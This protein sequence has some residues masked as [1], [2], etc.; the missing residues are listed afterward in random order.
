[1]GLLQK[2]PENTPLG[3]KVKFQESDGSDYPSIHNYESGFHSDYNSPQVFQA[4]FLYPHPQ[5]ISSFSRSPDW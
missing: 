4:T 5:G 3:I 2:Q 1:M